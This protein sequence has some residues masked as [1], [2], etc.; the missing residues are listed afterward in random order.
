MIERFIACYYRVL[1]IE[2]TAMAIKWRM[3]LQS[4][5]RVP[6]SHAHPIFRF[7]AYNGLSI[8][9]WVFYVNNNSCKSIANLNSMTIYILFMNCI[10][11]TISIFCYNLRKTYL[12]F[13]S[14]CRIT[15][16]TLLERMR[17]ALD[18]NVTWCELLLLARN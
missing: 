8:I 3:F 6:F 10:L 7:Y 16:L 5:Y 13:F 12:I 9:L 4:T 17:V 15:V 11:G 2:N 14:P 1:Y 18:N